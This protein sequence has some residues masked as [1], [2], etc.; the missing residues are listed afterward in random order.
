MA[1]AWEYVVRRHQDGWQ[2]MLGRKVFGPY[3]SRQCAVS[4]AINAA[5]AASRKG[6]P[7]AVILEQQDGRFVEWA[8]GA[9]AS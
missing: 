7:A 6:H 4:V 9:A 2:V 3:G 5:K 1:R 8:A